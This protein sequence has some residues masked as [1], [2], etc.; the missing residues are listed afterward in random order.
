MDKCEQ[1]VRRFVPCKEWLK[2]LKDDNKNNSDYLSP[3]K[4]TVI[5]NCPNFKS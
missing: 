3:C 5:Y 4:Y 1:C 2:V